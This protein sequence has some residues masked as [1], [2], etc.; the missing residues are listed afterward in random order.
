M[1]AVHGVHRA[2][3]IEV[4]SGALHEAH[5]LHDPVERAVPAFIPAVGV[6]QLARSVQADADQEP[7]LAQKLAP[8]WVQQNAV[9]LDRMLN[10]GA[11]F[12][13]EREVQR[14]KQAGNCRNTFDDSFLRQWVERQFRLQRTHADMVAGAAQPAAREVEAFYQA[15]RENFRNPES[16]RAAHIVKHVN[17][18]H[19]A[20]EARAS[21]RR[22][23]N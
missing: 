3:Y 4:H 10:R 8:R 14:Q 7:I 5:G 9:G 11:R 12:P 21:R 16:F 18:E 19:G 1:L 15:N 23:R 22:W 13:V 6:V 17:R 2:E 20:E